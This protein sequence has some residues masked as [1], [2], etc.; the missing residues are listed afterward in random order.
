MVASDT[1]TNA[2]AATIPCRRLI[3]DASIMVHDEH[4]HMNV[5]GI[6]G[7]DIIDVIQAFEAD[8]SPNN[9]DIRL[10]IC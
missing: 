5:I 3:I 8:F 1:P 7:L 9:D 4:I 10:V 2:I 6:T